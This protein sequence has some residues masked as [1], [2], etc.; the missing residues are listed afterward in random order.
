[1]AKPNLTAFR[2]REL[3]KY[4]KRD[5][6][7]YR[8]GKPRR[9]RISKSDGRFTVFIDGN[10]Y[11]E[12]R[13]VWLWH[14]GEW[15]KNCIDHIDRNPLNNRIE[16]LRDITQAENKQNQKASKNS[17]TGV[18]GIYFANQ[19]TGYSVEIMA[20]G[21]RHYLGYFK[22]IEDAAAAYAEGAKKYH[23][24]NPSANQG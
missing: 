23:K 14:H 16:N 12:H 8:I 20:L 17:L 24:Y 4:D 9:K 7:L 3:F 19:K 22:R 5:G 6:R 18:K 13:V 2:V 1:M 11:Q 15:P 21:V 10:L